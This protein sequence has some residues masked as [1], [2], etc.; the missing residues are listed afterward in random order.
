MS[1]EY[2]NKESKKYGEHIYKNPYELYRFLRITEK[3]IKLIPKRSGLKILDVGC[4]TGEFSIKQVLDEL[5]N[6]EVY[7]LD[8]S[9]GMISHASKMFEQCT[10]CVADAHHLPFRDGI[11]DLVISRQV[12]EHLSDPRKAMGE[13]KRVLKSDG[14]V[15]VSVP[16]SLGPIAPFYFIKKRSAGMQPIE[17]WLNPFLL[18]KLFLEAGFEIEVMD[19]TNPI[20]Y[21]EKLPSLFLPF[22]KKMD[23]ILLKLPLT[24]YLS[25]TLICRGKRRNGSI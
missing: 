4:G 25:R 20:P 15:I 8:F 14:Y 21:H 24:V 7:G 11:F 23:E 10:F 13:I 17:K 6:P 2:Y 16:S 12:V 9:N 22:I 1:R 18:R 19:G 5:C 3:I